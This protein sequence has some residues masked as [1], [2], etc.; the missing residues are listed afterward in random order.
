MTS[1]G[2]LRVF[3]TGSFM[4]V[5]LEPSQ[6]SSVVDFNV[7]K[8]AVTIGVLLALKPSLRPT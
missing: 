3:T 1:D 7:P 8:A 5:Q 2:W 6:Q 4:V